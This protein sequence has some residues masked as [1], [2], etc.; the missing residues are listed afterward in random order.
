M[1]V[2]KVKN[3]KDYL[4][5]E[6]LE[7]NSFFN[8][9]LIIDIFFNILGRDILIFKENNKSFLGVKE[10]KNISFLFEKPFFLTDYENEWVLFSEKKFVNYSLEVERILNNKKI[11]LFDKNKNLKKS[12]RKWQNKIDVNFF[13]SK[14]LT[15]IKTELFEFYSELEI[16]ERKKKEKTKFFCELERQIIKRNNLF[17]YEVIILR[18]KGKI[19]GVCFWGFSN[20]PNLGIS[21]ST[22]VNKFYSH[23]SDF[24]KYL[25]SKRMLEFDLEFQNVGGLNY[26]PHVVFKMKFPGDNYFFY[27]CFIKGKD[28]KP[29]DLFKFKEFRNRKPLKRVMSL[30]N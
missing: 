8:N 22:K 17:D 24:L 18:D 4:L 29:I 2:K 14:D 5:Y 20:K 3:I 21:F 10:G 9:F 13:K 30:I 11:V 12:V 7:S 23:L 16:Y 6:N 1:F 19:I 27:N 28:K 26:R 15:N 25:V